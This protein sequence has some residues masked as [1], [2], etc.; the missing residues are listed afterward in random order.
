MQFLIAIDLHA[1]VNLKFY[2]SLTTSIS[3][4]YYA[5]MPNKTLTENLQHL[6]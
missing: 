1:L 6:F 3:D 4:H 2:W 5:S